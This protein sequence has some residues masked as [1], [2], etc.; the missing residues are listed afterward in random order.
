[1]ADAP[2]GLSGWAPVARHQEGPVAAAPPPPPPPYDARAADGLGAPSSAAGG[3]GA[4]A[5]SPTVPL[6]PGEGDRVA[7]VSAAICRE[8]L[9]FHLPPDVLAAV[10][11]TPW[12]QRLANDV[13][14]DPR[15]ALALPAVAPP[16]IPYVSAV[17]LVVARHLANLRRSRGGSSVDDNEASLGF[18]RLGATATTTATTGG[19]AVDSLT[20]SPTGAV[21][22][23]SIDRWVSPTARSGAAAAGAGDCS[24][25]VVVNG[26]TVGATSSTDLFPLAS[27]TE[28]DMT[29]AKT[30]GRGAGGRVVRAFSPTLQQSLAVKVI[31]LG[32]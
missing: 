13:A 11:A 5:A 28:L 18:R 23:R 16:G 32:N 8:Y 27:L 9:R 2:P 26:L 15:L 25:G 20:G 7:D 10:D 3:F 21:Y 29:N 6:G 19:G 4:G 30:I 31:P 24:T 14:T 1:M 12:G 22:D 17:E